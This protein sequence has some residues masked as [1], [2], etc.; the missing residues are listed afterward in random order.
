LQRDPSRQ[1]RKAN[2]KKSAIAEGARDSRGR[3]PQ[4]TQLDDAAGVAHPGRVGTR[5]P[6]PFRDP[7]EGEAFLEAEEDQL[8]LLV[9]EGGDEVAD[10]ADLLVVGEM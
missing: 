10:P 5:K 2:V 8:P 9:V 6:E 1:E 3:T 4:L 7:G